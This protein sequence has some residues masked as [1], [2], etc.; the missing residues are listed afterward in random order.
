MQKCR[1]ANQQAIFFSDVDT[2]SESVQD[3]VSYGQ[4]P[5]GVFKPRVPRTR[6]GQKR[7]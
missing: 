6:V 1:H 7:Q 2:P 5:Q 4:T 3:A